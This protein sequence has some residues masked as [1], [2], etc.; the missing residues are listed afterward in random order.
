[1]DLLK[2]THFDGGTSKVRPRLE[3]AVKVCGSVKNKNAC[4]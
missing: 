4:I 3:I 2:T 1:M